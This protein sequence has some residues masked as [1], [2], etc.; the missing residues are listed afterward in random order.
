[1]FPWNENRNEGTFACSPERKPEQ[2]YIRQNHPFTKPPFYLPNENRA[3]TNRK[4]TVDS[5]Q[6][7]HFSV[8]AVYNCWC[9][10]GPVRGFLF[11]LFRKRCLRKNPKQQLAGRA[12]FTPRASQSP[13]SSHPCC[14]DNQ[15][16]TDRHTHTQRPYLCTTAGPQNTHT[17]IHIHMHIHT[18]IHTHTLSFSHSH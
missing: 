15:K 14:N 5:G 2:G 12:L 11:T 1:M 16:H 17:H 10:F 4:R 8:D 7:L 6:C 9:S 18:H 3:L 13:T